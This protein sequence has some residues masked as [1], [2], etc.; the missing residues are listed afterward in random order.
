MGYATLGG[1][2]LRGKRVVRFGSFELCLDTGELRK[3]GIRVRLQGKPFHILSALLQEPGHVVTREEL[4][5]RLWPADT[6]VDFES[7]LNT[8]VNRLRV[9]LGDSAENPIYIETLAR[10]G[11][12]FIAPVGVSNAPNQLEIVRPLQ[13]STVAS[14]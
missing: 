12:R 2:G 11:Y 9:A 8:A 13:P 14:E 6:F 10:L 7:G 5:S 3:L 1:E 4:R